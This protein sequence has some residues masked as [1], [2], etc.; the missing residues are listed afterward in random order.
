MKKF[1]PST[2]NA[3]KLEELLM[4]EHGLTSFPR[5]EYKFKADYLNAVISDDGTTARVKC[6]IFTPFLSPKIAELF[7][8]DNVR[9]GFET[10][11]TFL[12]YHYNDSPTFL[13]QTA[14]LGDFDEKNFILELHEWRLTQRVY[15]SEINHTDSNQEP[16][17]PDLFKKVYLSWDAALNCIQDYRSVLSEAKASGHLLRSR[18]IEAQIEQGKGQLSFK[19]TLKHIN[20][21][22]LLEIPELKAK[23]FTNACLVLAESH[24]FYSIISLQEII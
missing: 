18:S 20:D 14:E 22:S 3:V 5:S 8:V 6:W 9:I 1:D 10:H 17:L 24:E 11:I 2:F 19:A 7:N 23:S 21:G 16:I 4:T 12:L 13:M 15:V